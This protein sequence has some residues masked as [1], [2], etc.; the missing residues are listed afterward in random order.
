MTA[1]KPE[2]H[3]YDLLADKV[4]RIKGRLIVLEGTDGVSHG[5]SARAGGAED[6]RTPFIL[7]QNAAARGL[8]EPCAPGPHARPPEFDLTFA[9]MRVLWLHA[10]HRRQPE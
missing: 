4:K 1:R 7:H 5:A 3:G 9:H 8:I 2:F 10:S 6:Q